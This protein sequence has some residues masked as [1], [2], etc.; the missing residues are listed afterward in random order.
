MSKI[1]SKMKN[2]IQNVETFVMEK[3]KSG[4]IKMKP[5]WY[6]VVGSLSMVI[7][8]ASALTLSAF[9]FSIFVFSIRTHGP[10]VALRYQDLISNFP[11]WA[12]AT[13]V[14]GTVFGIFLLKKYDFSYRSNFLLIAAGFILSVIL[15]GIL[16]DRLGVDSLL[17]RRGFGQRLYQKYD[18]GY[19]QA[20]GKFPEQRGKVYNQN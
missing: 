8:L 1:K 3:I 7:G 11:V 4:R 6:F 19:R 13:A 10:M 15:A 18:G 14:M 9:V 20:P 16:I 2:K 5:R 17:I 12:V